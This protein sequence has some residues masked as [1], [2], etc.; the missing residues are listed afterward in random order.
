MFPQKGVKAEWHFL[1]GFCHAKSPAISGKNRN[2]VLAFT[3]EDCNYL[4]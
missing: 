1:K 2:H 4:A 3:P